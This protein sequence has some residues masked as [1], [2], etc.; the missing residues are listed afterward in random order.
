MVAPTLQVTS[1]GP[2]YKNKNK[3]VYG[4]VLDVLSGSGYPKRHDYLIG[5]EVNYRV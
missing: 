1:P 3:E 5:A 4:S 2:I